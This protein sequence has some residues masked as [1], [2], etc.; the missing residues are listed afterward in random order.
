VLDAAV[1][2]GAVPLPE[3][4]FDGLRVV[5]PFVDKLGRI[6]L[7]PG[8]LRTHE[9]EGEGATY[10][11]PTFTHTGVFNVEMLELLEGAAHVADFSTYPK[12]C[13][14]FGDRLRGAIVGM[15]V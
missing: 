11:L 7:A 4:L 10:D 8:G 3:G 15:K 12:P 1:P 9:A 13:H 2:G 5:K 6:L 14:F